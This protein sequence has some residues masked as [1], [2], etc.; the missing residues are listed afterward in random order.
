MKWFRKKNKKKETKEGPVYHVYWAVVS[1]DDDT[2]NYFIADSMLGNLSIF[3]DRRRAEVAKNV[4]SIFYD[5]KFRVL[6]VL[7]Q[8][9]DE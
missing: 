9:I 2:K 8:E 7:V 5:G 1:T 6:K 3:M 4:Y